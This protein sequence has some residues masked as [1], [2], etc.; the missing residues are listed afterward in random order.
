M[1]GDVLTILLD[2]LL[3]P[4]LLELIKETKLGKPNN[5]EV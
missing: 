2:N 3:R 4:A 1:R 5:L